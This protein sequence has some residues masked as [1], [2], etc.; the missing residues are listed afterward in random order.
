[1][2]QVN[3]GAVAEYERVKERWDFLSNQKEDLEKARAN[4][5][6]AIKE[7]D[8][9]TRD[10]FITTFEA[11]AQNFDQMFK[12]LFGG[13]IT[14]LELTNPTDL[15][16]TG[17]EV[18]VQ[19]PGKKLQNLVLLSG[20]ERALTAA[21]LLF[22]LMMVRPSPFVVLDEVD[23][24][25]DES[26]VE[27]FAELLRDFSKNSQFIVISHNR[28]TMEAAD[29]LY[30]VSMQEPGI[31]NLISV[32]LAAEEAPVLESNEALVADIGN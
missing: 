15:L 19:P 21:A 26:N 25:L 5:N 14:S 11:V 9:S 3:T 16:E 22:A 27:R 4:L 29:N 20:G 31:S 30:G 28:A 24:A 8:D 12:R 10:I 23:A 6:H 2:G 32:R 17:I 1:M 13:G 7:I 18:I